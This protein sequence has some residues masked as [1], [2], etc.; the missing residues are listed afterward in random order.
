REALGG[1]VHAAALDLAVGRV[2]DRPVFGI[3]EPLYL[4]PHAPT[5]KLAPAGCGLVSLLRYVPDG[6]SADHDD[7]DDRVAAGRDHARLR[8]LA[9]QVG[10][11][12]DDIVH[13]RYLH[14]LLV[15][16]AFPTARGGGLR[17]RPT[18]DALGL[19][20]VFLAGDWVGSEYQ[21]ADASSA[22]GEAAAVRAVDHARQRIDVRR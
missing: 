22:S 21:L 18:V 12:G 14:R 19:P 3:D 8:R 17:G 15:A 20:G 9:E 4:S 13:E 16:N 6:E 5:A 11:A 7:D 2:L 10:I 1:A